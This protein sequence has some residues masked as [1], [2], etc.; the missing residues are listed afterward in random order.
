M[1]DRHTCVASVCGFLTFT[2]PL[3]RPDAY[4]KSRRLLTMPSV[5]SWQACSKIWGVRVG[6]P[7]LSLNYSRETRFLCMGTHNAAV[8]CQYC[9]A[10]ISFEKPAT[11]LPQIIALQ[12][13]K[14]ERRRVYTPAEV[15]PHKPAETKKNPFDRS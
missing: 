5:P 14:C 3:V 2:Q 11:R 13:P 7:W 1:F 8:T 15:R 10:D 12:C 6:G 9:K 4:R